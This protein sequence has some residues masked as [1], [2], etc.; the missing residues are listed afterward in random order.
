MLFGGHKEHDEE[1]RV[2]REILHVLR[3]LYHHL[4]PHS[5]TTQARISFGGNMASTPGTQA[6]GSTLTATFV[7]L[8]ADGIT[9]TPGAKLTTN[10]TWTSSDTTIAT[11]VANADGTATVTGVAAGTVTITGTGGV[12]TDADGTA[13]SP[14]TA[15][16]TDTVTVPTGRTVSAQV[17][18]S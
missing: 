14:L 4:V 8:E 12:F 5:R 10:P 13:T 17:N 15:S 11:V 1:M 18:F 6:V 9:V 3:K 2:L 16:N 7:P